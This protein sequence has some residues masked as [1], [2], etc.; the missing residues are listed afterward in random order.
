[1]N[2]LQMT[3]IEKMN[4]TNTILDKLKSRGITIMNSYETRSKKTHINEIIKELKTKAKHH[5]VFNRALNTNEDIMKVD[6]II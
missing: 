4:V 5:N 6:F 2:V 1:M 3:L